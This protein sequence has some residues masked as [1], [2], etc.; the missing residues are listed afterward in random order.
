MMKNKNLFPIQKQTQ[1]N[2]KYEVILIDT[3]HIPLPTN[4]LA[5]DLSDVILYMISND[6]L[7]IANSKSI[8]TIFKDTDKKNVK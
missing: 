5:M 7:D 6:P 2:R 1:N 3:N 8:M 4:L